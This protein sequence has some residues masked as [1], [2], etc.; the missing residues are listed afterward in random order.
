MKRKNVRLGTWLCIS[1][2][3][4]NIGTI[5]KISELKLMDRV[6]KLFLPFASVT[7][8]IVDYYTV[9]KYDNQKLLDVDDIYKYE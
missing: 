6:T 4:F 9:K 2:K 7:I 1:W 3:M 5:N 8:W